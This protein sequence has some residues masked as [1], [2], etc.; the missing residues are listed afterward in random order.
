LISLFTD[1]AVVRTNALVYL[2]VSLPGLPALLITLAGVGY[3]RGQQDTRRP[4]WVALATA[5]FNLVFEAILIYGLDF[6]VGPAPRSPTLAQWI[7]AACY[8]RWIARAVQGFDVAL[9]P[10][11]AAI[12][13]LARGGGDLLLPP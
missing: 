12:G 13:R 4:L 10:D 11:R 9:T 8:L 2:R 7:A 3:L 1:D 5:L 6:G